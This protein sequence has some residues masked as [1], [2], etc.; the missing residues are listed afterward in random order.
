MFTVSEDQ[1]DSAIR[2][3][4]KNVGLEM[5]YENV[6]PPSRTARKSNWMQVIGKKQ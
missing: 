1:T 6:M 5:V 2:R 4:I 3:F